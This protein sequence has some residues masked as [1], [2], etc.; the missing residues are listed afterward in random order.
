MHYQKLQI[1]KCLKI[2]TQ[3]GN[4]EM[5]KIADKTLAEK[6]KRSY[7]WAYKNMPTLVTA[8]HNTEK[9]FS[10]KD[11]KIAVCLHVTKETSVLA[12]G[13]KKL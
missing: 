1:L 6:G 2:K 11:T 5:S 3:T 9:N 10:F 12:M 8:I 7:E 4:I 13:L